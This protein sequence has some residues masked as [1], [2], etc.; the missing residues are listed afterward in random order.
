MKQKYLFSLVFLLL[1]ISLFTSCKKINTNSSQ[2]DGLNIDNYPVIDGS[3]S[4][5]PLNTII[6]CELLGIKY[7][8]QETKETSTRST[9]SVE[10]K[11]KGS[12]KKK[13]SQVVWSSQTHGSLIN[14]IDHKADLTLSARKLSDDERAYAESKGVTLIETPIALDAFVF[15]VGGSSPVE[16]LTTQNIQDIYTGKVRKWSE[17]GITIYEGNPDV[18]IHALVR[19]ANSGSQELM[20][21][22][23]MKDLDYFDLPTYEENL[24][25]TMAGIID[26]V[27]W[28]P[29]AIAYTVYYYNDFIIRP[30]KDSLKKIAIDGVFPNKESLSNRSYPYTTEVYAVIRSD[31]D[32]SSMTYKIYEWLQTENGKKTISN[33]GYIPT[34]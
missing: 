30:H 34:N 14:I 28:R 25:F 2:I 1:F 23:I 24:I 26:A 9:W 10:P 8:W 21:E 20:D 3:T 18:E 13:L 5:L 6:A 15:I 33:S 16:G 4:S 31:T 29:H 19:N 12:L 27:A 17:L 11:V 22:L 32:P 7:E